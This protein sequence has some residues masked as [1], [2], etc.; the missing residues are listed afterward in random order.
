MQ[1]G[2][3]VHA[4]SHEMQYQGNAIRFHFSDL[5]SN[6]FLE[7]KYIKNEQPGATWNSF[8]GFPKFSDSLAQSGLLCIQAWNFQSSYVILLMDKI[9]HC[10]L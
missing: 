6:G 10:P 4:T 7:G 5:E 3:P 9:L 1:E 2:L 8:H